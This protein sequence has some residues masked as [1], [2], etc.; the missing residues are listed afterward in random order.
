[1]SRS[2]KAKLRPKGPSEIGIST[3]RKRAL[4]SRLV[5]HFWERGWLLWT[6]QDNDQ[7]QWSLRFVD[8]RTETH[9][10][11]TLIELWRWW[12]QRVTWAFVA[13]ASVEDALALYLSPD[14]ALS[15]AIRHWSMTSGDSCLMRDGDIVDAYKSFF[16]HIQG[17]LKLDWRAH[18]SRLAA[19]CSA[20]H[21]TLFFELLRRRIINHERTALDQAT[22]TLQGAT[23]TPGRL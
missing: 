20:H 1:M 10:F 11:E 21:D 15:S 17:D 7:R 4:S 12:A 19:S 9:T 5:E 13:E 22:A 18:E 2:F 3:P 6:H 14:D 16:L 8:E 23:R